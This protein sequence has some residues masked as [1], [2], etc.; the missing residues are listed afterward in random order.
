MNNSELIHHFYNSF[1]ERNAEAMISCYDNNIVFTD[2]AFGTLNGD[3]AKNMWRML[4]H[5]SK[6]N[7]KITYENVQADEKTGSANWIAEYIFAQTG[8]KV[9]N[10][11]AAK[12]EF[13][14]GKIIKHTDHFNLWRWTQ[15]AMGWKGL[16]FGW[17]PFIQS[18]IRKQTNQLLKAYT[19]SI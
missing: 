5:R 8:R 13:Q 16:L 11:I 14:D 12:F 19:K 4:I 2:P 10:R 3:D 7:L 9:I 15:Q 6:G 18:K 1:A 17:T